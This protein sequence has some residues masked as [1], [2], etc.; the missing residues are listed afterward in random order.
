MLNLAFYKKFGYE[1]FPLKTL[2]II[3]ILWNTV[4]KQCI[5]VLV[6]MILLLLLFEK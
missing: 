4:I 1:T 6:F 2:L 3:C 5:P